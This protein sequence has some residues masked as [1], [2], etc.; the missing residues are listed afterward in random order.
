M[1]TFRRRDG[2]AVTLSQ[3]LGF[4][5]VPAVQPVRVS[6]VAISWRCAQETCR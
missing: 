1:G 2:W 6:V 4:K 3:N 5:T